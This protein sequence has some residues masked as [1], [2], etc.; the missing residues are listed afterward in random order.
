[1]VEGL[2]AGS[3]ILSRDIPLPEGTTLAIEEDL[4]VLQVLSAQAEVA[5]A[6]EGAEGTEAAEA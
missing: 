1:S 2:E 3:Q 4:V 5:E 6:G